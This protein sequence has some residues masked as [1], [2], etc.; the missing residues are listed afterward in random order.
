[1]KEVH[2]VRKATRTKDSK[3]VDKDPEFNI[4]DPTERPKQ[5]TPHKPSAGSRNAALNPAQAGD[6][7]TATED[8][9]T[10]AL[11]F[12]GV[13]DD[14][15]VT[16]VP[17][18]MTIEAWSEFLD[19]I[20]RSPRRSSDGQNNSLES[21]SDDDWDSDIEDNWPPMNTRVNPMEEIK[22]RDRAEHPF[23]EDNDPKYFQEELTGLRAWKIELS[24][25]CLDSF[26]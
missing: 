14:G 5:T 1:V 6:L 4:V 18:D 25:L 24:Q 12:D 13:A 15:E 22:R 10:V 9:T 20:Y 8:A 23:P 2:D 7:D 26:E 16:V 21:D 3:N 17:A 11:T 19:E